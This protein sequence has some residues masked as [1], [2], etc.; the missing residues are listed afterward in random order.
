MMRG[1][2]PWWCVLC[3]L[4]LQLQPIGCWQR[5]RWVRARAWMQSATRVG[6]PAPCSG[7]LV[8]DAVVSEGACFENAAGR[9]SRFTGCS[10]GKITRH[11]CG[12][13]SGGVLPDQ[14]RE[15][16]C[17]VGAATEPWRS[18]FDCIDS[19]LHPTLKVLSFGTTDCSD[20]PVLVDTVLLQPPPALYQHAAAASASASAG[21]APRQQHSSS[22]VYTRGTRSAALASGF[23]RFS[24]DGTHAT[25]TSFSALPA[26]TRGLCPLSPPPL[27]PARR[28]KL[29]RCTIEGG[30]SVALKFACDLTASPT[31]APTR[32]PTP[33]PTPAPT[34]SPTPPTPA[35]TAPP[36]PPRTE[37]PTRAPTLA[38]TG[39]PTPVPTPGPTAPPTPMPTLSPTVAP[40]PPPTPACGGLELL[41]FGQ[42]K[43]QCQRGCA[44]SFALLEPRDVRAFRSQFGSFVA[45]YRSTLPR[46]LTQLPRFLYYFASAVDP[47]DSK[48]VLDD[49]V[50]DWY[51]VVQVPWLERKQRRPWLPMGTVVKG[52]RLAK[53]ATALAG[54]WA[55]PP[56]IT[57]QC[58]SRPPTPAPTVA[59]TSAPSPH[60]TPS[61]SPAPTPSPSAAPTPSPTPAP[62]PACPTLALSGAAATPADA[63]LCMGKYELTSRTAFGRPVYRHIGGVSPPF[64]MYF[65]EA[66]QGQ[67]AWVV[68]RSV[69]AAE[70]LATSCVYAVG[71]A[72]RF[73]ELVAAGGWMAPDREGLMSEPRVQPSLRAVCTTTPPPTPRTSAPTGAPSPSPTP[74]PTAAPSPSPTAVPS[75]A[76]TPTR[77]QE[78]AKAKNCG[79]CIHLPQ[80]C[81]WCAFEGVCLLGAKWGPAPE[82]GAVCK[83]GWAFD[84]CRTEAPTGVPTPVPTAPPTS[85]PSPVPTGSPT[86]APTMPPTP[87]RT[88]APTPPP[89]PPT[90]V[91][92][93]APPTPTTLSPTPVPTLPPTPVP[94]PA[95]TLPPSPA[96][97]P[98]PGQLPI[99]ASEFTWAPT[100]VPTPPTPFPTPFPTPLPAAGCA[101]LRVLG[102]ESGAPRADCMG[103]FVRQTGGDAASRH[104]GV[105]ATFASAADT[106]DAVAR[107]W[108]FFDARGQWTIGATQPSSDGVS[109]SDRWLTVHDSA[110]N[111]EHVEG[112]WQLSH[113]GAW[114]EAAAVRVECSRAPSFRIARVVKL[115]LQMPA[116][117][118]VGGFDGAS[119]SGSAA[120][121]A[122]QLGLVAA[123]GV[124]ANAVAVV[125]VGS[126]TAGASGAWAGEGVQF[127]V[128][129][130]SA[131]RDAA[132]DV[133]GRASH[134]RFLELLTMETAK[135]GLQ[136][137]ATKGLAL[138]VLG[139][140]RPPAAP[141]NAGMGAVRVV[142]VSEERLWTAQAASNVVL[143]G[144]GGRGWYA[145][146]TQDQCVR[147]CCAPHAIPD[148]SPLTP[149]LPFVFPAGG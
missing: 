116:A 29:G 66:L 135:H 7:T 3:A 148:C 17:S 89:T 100:A 60:P 37:A 109:S 63:R 59:P 2:L 30:W 93:P 140:D 23:Y 41:V 97:T 117:A 145:W 85:S 86:T 141:D 57:F 9:S 58:T 35:P 50:R 1:R 24:C 131:S 22:C 65:I 13:L 114:V 83:S 12:P 42:R 44:A 138:R 11:E 126:S 137:A 106:F 79:W 49:S 4:L 81:G 27:L 87:M 94:S 90:P 67:S 136:P 84:K 73:P 20:T 127:D 102:V 75:P 110:F 147:A 31:P 134:P 54:V 144:I 52:W 36:T 123:L 112:T 16:Q 103:I 88:P 51:D 68:G 62:T 91:P 39:P 76:P 45:I 8:Q 139:V 28:F 118:R 74:A 146:H 25:V 15:G 104:A 55:A 10:G 47:A 95:P 61:P 96:P 46:S 120:L 101:E 92:T 6:D 133:R 34:R 113:E 26:A 149:E 71:A 53:P 70:P 115:R 99:P 72:S 105:R 18:T 32:A 129:V 19:G 111:P 43:A 132:W 119:G 33:P 69:S 78:C 14:L 38:P 80:G 5:G 56:R 142:A 124:A 143:P 128:D 125:A 130:A 82:T 48:W 121:L 108:L 64:L 21:V 98:A 122:M 77:A 40:T 107:K